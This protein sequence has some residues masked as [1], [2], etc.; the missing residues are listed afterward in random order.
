M[1]NI[2]GSYSF[3]P[4]RV[5]NFIKTSTIKIYPNPV[6]NSLTVSVNKQDNK[7]NTVKLYNNV[8]QLIITKSFAINT[9]LDLTSLASGTY[10]IRVDDG[11]EIKI[12]TIQKK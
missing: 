3:S 5:V 4:I 2:D 1:I 11:T 8:G 10:L 6:I 12:F 7:L 9:Q